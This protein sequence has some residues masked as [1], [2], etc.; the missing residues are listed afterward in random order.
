MSAVPPLKDAKKPSQ[1]AVAV[2]PL[3][4]DAVWAAGWTPAEARLSVDQF[5][6]GTFRWGWQLGIDCTSYPP[7]K[8]ALDQ[9]LATPCGLPFEVTGPTRAPARFETEAARRR[10]HKHINRLKRSTLRDLAMFGLSVWHH[11]LA[12]DGETGRVE[13]APFVQGQKFNPDQT[14]GGLDL[15]AWGVDYGGVQRWPLSAVGWTAY[16]L[17]GVIG[18]YAITLGGQRIQ[19]P[20][21]GETVG[22]W[23]V[24]GEGDQP[25]LDGSICSL[26][27]EFTGGM[28]TRRA[29][30]NLGVSAGK[31]SPW[32]DMPDA[33]AVGD[34]EGLAA[35]DV[36]RGLGSE[37]AAA[38]FPS[39]GKHGVFELTTAGAADYFS[40][41]LR[42]S[43]LMVALAIMGRGS[44]LAKTDAQYQGPT[45]KDVPEAL[46]RRD[47]VALER[48]FNGI[49][50]M[51]AEMNSGID[52]ADAPKLNGHLP[53]EE[54]IARRESEGKAMIQVAQILKAEG[55]AGCAVTQVRASA[56]AHRL[57]TMAPVVVGE[58]SANIEEWHVQ[59]KIVWPDAALAALGLP[60]L[61]DG[62]GSP[63]RLAAERLAGK[64]KSG[65]KASQGDALI[66]GHP[67]TVPGDAEPAPK[68]TE[69]L[70]P[71]GDI[72]PTPTTSPKGPPPAASPRGDARA[73]E[74]RH[75]VRAQEGDEEQA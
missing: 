25:H 39:G 22:E 10:W 1:S 20:R 63:E 38:V 49:A 14:G 44:A 45:E 8:C 55:D 50:S 18:Y 24:V 46:V 74:S 71:G 13:V 27:M 56:I 9:R 4:S 15:S 34:P 72:T 40:K 48:A 19:L 30:A 35:Q 33:V 61:P 54:Q 69:Q 60:P 47:V 66:D 68:P 31:A 32:Y 6:R 41:D 62:A 2:P 52:E 73:R 43:I 57:G 37:Q 75:G 29:R 7:I 65:A 28:L 42:D 64:D 21:P 58:G 67:D 3:G 59:Q 36:M 17:L 16:P 12:V 5:K 51:L 26:D 11:P 23:T 53:D 70:A